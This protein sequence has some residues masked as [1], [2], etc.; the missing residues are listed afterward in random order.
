MTL[1]LVE[2][3]KPLTGSGNVRKQSI[4]GAKK[5]RKKTRQKSRNIQPWNIEK[6][7][8]QNPYC[9][10]RPKCIPNT[11]NEWKDCNPP[12][13]FQELILII[14]R[15]F[16]GYKNDRPQHGNP[17]KERIIFHYHLCSSRVC[18]SIYMTLSGFTLTSI[19]IGSA[20]MSP[21]SSSLGQPPM[22]ILRSAFMRYFPFT[23]AMN[24]GKVTG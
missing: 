10:M 15:I 12:K 9:C 6:N 22:G 16:K 13:P 2:I 4:P 23:R 19:S 1:S 24:D 17:L 7:T 8:P 11:Y 14:F 18:Q 5:H 3:I 21:R 20:R